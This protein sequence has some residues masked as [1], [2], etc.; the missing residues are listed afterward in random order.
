MINAKR[1]IEILTRGR[2][3]YGHFS[4]A[5]LTTTVSVLS[6][7]S[8]NIG[9]AWARNIS[10]VN[11]HE[12]GNATNVPIINLNLYVYKAYN[13]AFQGRS[14]LSSSSAEMVYF[15]PSVGEY[16]VVLQRTVT[17][18]TGAAYYALAWY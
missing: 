9:C 2:Y 15:K 1:A 10:A 11:E 8:M 3:Q 4:D 6:A 12:S 16:K 17:T 7:N 13:M 18:Y 5:S 14:T